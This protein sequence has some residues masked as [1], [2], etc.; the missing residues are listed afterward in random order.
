M[1]DID[2]N[3]EIYGK[4]VADFEV[5][6]FE[7]LNILHLRSHLERAKREL[8][9]EQ[10]IKV[11]KYDMQLI[12]NAKKVIEHIGSIYSFP[13][14]EQP[15]SQWW[16]HLDKVADGKITFKLKTVID[17]GDKPQRITTMPDDLRTKATKKLEEMSE[18]VLKQLY[19][20]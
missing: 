15:L 5:S 11:M 4:L 16:W 19:N 18:A 10:T 12:E 9:E 14:S 1:S 8:T 13:Q 7:T 20:R 17:R 3:I 2:Q 6:P